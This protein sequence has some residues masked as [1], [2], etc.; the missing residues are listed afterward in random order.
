MRI[1]AVNLDPCNARL[2]TQLAAYYLE[3]GKLEE[4]IFELEKATEINPFNVENWENLADAYQKVA[5]INITQSQKDNALELIRKSQEIFNK[6]SAYN[7]RAPKNSREKTEVTN[8][9]MLSIYKARL[10]AENIDHDRYYKKL[11]NLIFAS[12]FIIDADNDGVPDLWRIS[13]SQNG[14]LQVDIEKNFTRILN[15]G[16]GPSYLTIKKDIS[17]EPKKWYTVNLVIGSDN[18]ENTPIMN[19]FS[20]KGKNPQYQLK[21]ITL[22]PE[23]INVGSTFETTED[24]EDGTQWVRIDIPGYTE[25]AINMKSI[26]IWLEQAIKPFN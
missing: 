19:I 23:I 26:E 7:C 2:R 6:I 11:D 21:N 9:L 12:D 25:K 5:T 10:L 17:L 20:R 1:E 14:L 4:G 24:I 15:K 18:T 3:Q 8:E 13:N 16:D 22:S